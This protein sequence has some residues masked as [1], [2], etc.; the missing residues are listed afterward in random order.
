MQCTSI[1]AC[2]RLVGGIDPARCLSVMLDVGTDNKDLLNDELYIVCCF[3]IFQILSLTPYMQGWNHSRVR[4][5][6]Y[7][8]FIDK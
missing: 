6:E 7:D 2:F 8:Q 3:D 5:A 4:G 1:D